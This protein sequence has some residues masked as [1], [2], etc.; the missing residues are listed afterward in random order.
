[1]SNGPHPEGQ[2]PGDVAP[3]EVVFD[4]TVEEPVPVRVE[5]NVFHVH[6]AETDS[7][8]VKPGAGDG[9]KPHGHAI[10][11]CGASSR[12][13]I[14][15]NLF[16]APISFTG[17]DIP[18]DWGPCNRAEL[19]Q[20]TPYC[21]YHIATPSLHDVI[22][23]TSG[24]NKAKRQA[25]VD[26]FNGLKD[27]PALT[28]FDIVSGGLTLESNHALTA[29][30]PGLVIGFGAHEAQWSLAHTYQTFADFCAGG[31]SSNLLCSGNTVTSDEAQWVEQGWPAA[32][33]MEGATFTGYRTTLGLPLAEDRYQNSSSL[34]RELD[35]MS[36]ALRTKR[37]GDW[38]TH[39]DVYDLN[40]YFRTQYGLPEVRRPYKSP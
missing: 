34:D 32:V 7:L 8:L 4:Y 19:I 14:T 35:M 22:Y 15:G 13:Q 3:V 36:D 39:Y 17:L 29:S 26:T 18:A 12:L 24:D 20:L 30:G 33:T 5:E 16:Y 40:N 28:W 21:H 27:A 9:A 2:K 10:R 25:A 1:M 23:N 31:D 37:R 11:V 38:S 6:H